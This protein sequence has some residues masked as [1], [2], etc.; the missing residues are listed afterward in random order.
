MAL[1]LLQRPFLFANTISQHDQHRSLPLTSLRW[2]QHRRISGAVA[3]RNRICIFSTS[4]IHAFAEPE[5]Y[6]KELSIVQRRRDEVLAAYNRDAFPRSG[7]TKLAIRN[8][9]RWLDR[10]EH[11]ITFYHIE[12]RLPERGN[13]GTPEHSL[14]IWMDTQRN[15]KRCLDLGK[16]C[17]HLMTPGRISILESMPWWGW[18]GA[19]WYSYY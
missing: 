19:A 2:Q 12:G 7:Y 14:A 8:E 18:D 6:E 11:V 17:N 5:A 15:A 1:V 16:P 13:K 3:H 9:Q 10:L 4:D